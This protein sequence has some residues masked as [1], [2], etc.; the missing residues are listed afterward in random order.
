MLPSDA[1]APACAL[2]AAGATAGWWRE[3]S[4]GRR[5]SA[6]AAERASAVIECVRRLGLAALRTPADVY[7]E[8]ESGARTL[9]PAVDGVLVFVED[10]SELACVHAGGARVAAFAGMRVARTGTALPALASACGGRI[11]GL[12]GLHP[13]D[14][15][16]LAQP[17][18]GA[19]GRSGAVVLSARVAIDRAGEDALAALVDHAGF[20]HALA[21]EREAD[22]ERAEFDALT[23]LLAPRA[24]RERL[25]ATLERAARDPLA[26][27][28]LLFVDTDHFKSW[29]DTLGHASG[30][31]LLRSL[32]GIF[33]A[34]ASEPG[35]FAA[36]NGGDEFCLVFASSEKSRAL[37]RAER[38][39][40]AVAGL[41]TAD[42]PRISASIGVA[43]YPADA[44]DAAALLECA[45]AAMYHTK[46]SGRNGVSYRT[47]GPGF[48]RLDGTA[49]AA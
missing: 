25:A 46:R 33:A 8:L 28:T 36:R 6:R 32:A 7:A 22:R 5:A 27:V 4:R 42:G 9:V 44:A 11:A 3:R 12:P 45:D 31:A 29:N 35:D 20:A 30:D 10:G 24:F 34:A 47:A 14:A 2:L 16:C 19:R 26:R 41:A 1:I 48:A 21:C 39:R 13:S 37:V 43:A 15:W 17:L 38:L 18:A 40:A 49:T 23:G